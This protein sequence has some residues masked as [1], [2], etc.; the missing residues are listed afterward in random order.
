M[1]FQNVNIKNKPWFYAVTSLVKPSI[2][3]WIPYM[4]CKTMTLQNETTTDSSAL[5][6]K[7]SPQHVHHNCAKAN[8]KQQYWL[9]L[10]KS[11]CF[12]DE[13]KRSCS[14]IRRNLPPYL[15]LF[16]KSKSHL[17]FINEET[18]VLKN[19]RKH[20]KSWRY[21]WRRGEIL[22]CYKCSTF[23]CAKWQS[24]IFKM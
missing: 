4:V 7:P 3:C 1:D 16:V 17:Y 14:S 2:M 6:C 9:A 24:D 15:F 19:W 12:D 23:V 8:I 13:V 22:Q 11:T 21:D 5:L 10:L 18:K 20:P